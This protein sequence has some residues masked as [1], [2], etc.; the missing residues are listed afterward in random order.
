MRGFDF[1]I[2]AERQASMRT[3][4]K[5][6]EPEIS[7]GPRCPTE[8]ERAWVRSM[9]EKVRLQVPKGVFRYASHE[10]ANQEWEAWMGETMAAMAQESRDE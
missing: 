6:K 5:R 10:Q 8:A 1:E 4:G 7:L 2:Q 3:I 9:A